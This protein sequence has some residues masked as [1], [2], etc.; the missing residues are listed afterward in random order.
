MKYLQRTLASVSR[1]EARYRQATEP[2]F[3]KLAEHLVKVGQQTQ[4]EIERV[5]EEP[6]ERDYGPDLAQFNEHVLYPKT[7]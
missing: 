2:G 5:L 7:T 1:D 3:V 6:E 4:S